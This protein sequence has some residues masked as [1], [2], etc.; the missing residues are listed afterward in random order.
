MNLLAHIKRKRKQHRK[1]QPIKRDIFNHVSSMVRTYGLKK[2]FLNTIEN[3]DDY[4]SK[5]KFN[6]SRVRIKAPMARSLFSLVT[7]DEYTLILS[8]IKKI[9]NS[10]LKFA[11]SPDEILWCGPLYRLNPSLEPEKLA[12]YHFETLFLHERAKTNNQNQDL[13]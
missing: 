5:E 2:S 9:D 8:I 12:R 3:A 11:C 6:A 7:Q 10:Y 4:L 13:T 1:K